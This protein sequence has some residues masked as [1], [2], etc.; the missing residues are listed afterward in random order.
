[1]SFDYCGHLSQEDT[2]FTLKRTFAD[3]RLALSHAMEYARTVAIPVH[4][5]GACYGLIPLLFVLEEFGWPRDVKSLFSIGG[6]F[7]MHEIINFDG[8]NPYL[9]KRGLTFKSK[10]DLM[11]FMIAEKDTFVRDKQKYIEALTEYLQ[12]VFT[13]LED[14]ISYER[15]GVM[16]YSNVDFYQTFYEFLTIDLPEISVP[17]YFPCLFFT[18]AHDTVLDLKTPKG[19]EE[20]T[21]R[22]MALAS[23]AKFFKL[24]IDHFGRGADHYVIGREGVKFLI[25]S[26]V[27]SALDKCL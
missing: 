2:Q 4:V 26:E 5:V 10:D 20:Y 12:Q 1:M 27:A 17:H 21:Q 3:T 6:L 19:E 13:E 11:G 14:V 15:F 23:H 25:A 24:R 9:K 7:S 16:T 22:I 18:G 8:Y